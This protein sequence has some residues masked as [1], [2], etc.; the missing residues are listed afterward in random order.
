MKNL[1]IVGIDPGTTTGYAVLNLR[2]NIMDIGSSKSYCLSSLIFEIT[3]QGIPLIVGCDKKNIPHFVEDFAIKTGAKL[4]SPKEDMKVLE[5]K[6]L[7]SSYQSHLK[8]KSF[9]NNNNNNLLKTEAGNDHERD[10][11]ASAL[12]AFRRKRTLLEKIENHLIREDKL[13]ILNEI[14]KIV[15]STD[16]GLPIKLAV[17]IIEKT[18][19]NNVKVIKKAIENNALPKE[20]NRFYENMDFKISMLDKENIYLKESNRK[21]KQQAESIKKDFR[22]MLKKIKRKSEMKSDNAL[23]E[24]L[25]SKEEII[26]RYRFEID[27]KDNSIRRLTKKIG[28]LNNVLNNSE[29]YAII[30]KIK[31]LGEGYRREKS[32]IKQDEIIF[33]ED[34]S[35]CSE[36]NIDQLK[37][38]VSIIICER[39]NKIIKDNF[40]VIDK[41]KIDDIEHKET[42]EFLFV[43]REKFDISLDKSLLL[44]KI[45]KDYREKRNS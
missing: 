45:V 33:V 28:L 10:A 34:G 30:K 44:Q 4:I 36:N 1:I 22:M 26:N 17:D 20:F 24:K 19:D 18:D 16:E 8:N 31:D 3:K 6:D 2:G 13:D 5:K 14:T 29:K 32:N 43:D 15:F 27:N 35:I 41:S 25:N 40:V 7:I 37:E 38:K 12:Y 42:D 21:L 23:M 39:P 9:N 11:L